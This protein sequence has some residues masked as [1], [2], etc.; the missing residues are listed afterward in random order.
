MLVRPGCFCV[1]VSLWIYPQT[2]L[3]HGPA[4]SFIPVLSL[5]LYL[6]IT[7]QK[8][9]PSDS[10]DC[11]SYRFMFESSTFIFSGPAQVFEPGGLQ[12]RQALCQSLGRRT[13][14]V[15]IRNIGY[16]HG[17]TLVRL[18]CCSFNSQHI[19]HILCEFGILTEFFGLN[20]HGPISDGKLCGSRRLK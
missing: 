18:F 8:C 11:N 15:S 17:L 9:G 2:R 10:F 19:G 12:H 7:A 13:H 5:V 6:R 14:C 1:V 4:P 16:S 20:G 3:I